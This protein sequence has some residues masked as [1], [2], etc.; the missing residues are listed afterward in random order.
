M[1]L[2]RALTS[3]WV[4]NQGV[5]H[6]GGHGYATILVQDLVEW[7]IAV[8]VGVAQTRATFVFLML[9]MGPIGMYVLWRYW[10][11]DIGKFRSWGAMIAGLFYLL[12]LGTVQTFF[13]PLEAF[14]VMYG[15]LP[16]A[17]WSIVRYLD[18]SRKTNL[19]LLLAVQLIF[20]MIGFI[21]PQFVAYGMMVG[22]ILLGYIFQRKNDWKTT[23]KR[24]FGVV[25]VLL[26]TNIYWLGPVAYYSVYGAK[27]YVEAKNNQVSTPDFEY[28]SQARGR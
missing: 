22:A 18:D 25:I 28:M 14:A 12:N 20:S 5:G 3:V 16:W 8:A 10:F 19:W 23:F 21:P 26:V 9:W 1:N 24:I 11:R 15:L 27:N 7:A 6:I 4:G 13:A 17:I 2:K